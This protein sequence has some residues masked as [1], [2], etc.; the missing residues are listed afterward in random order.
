MWAY[1]R[2]LNYAKIW[3]SSERNSTSVPSSLR[4]FDLAHLLA[5]ELRE[6]GLSDV[7]VN[8]FGIV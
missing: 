4:Q 8:N 7:E 3:T 6:L 5:F 2:F 1:K